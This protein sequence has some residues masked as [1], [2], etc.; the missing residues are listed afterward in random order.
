[1][2]KTL[3]KKILERIESENLE[4]R[5]KF[6]FTLREV[7]LWVGIGISAFLASVS[8][9]SFIFQSI[10]TILLPPHL[11]V[12]FGL[13]RIGLIILFIVLIVF[14]V[15]HTEKG[16][17]RKN[18]AYVAFGSIIIGIVGYIFFSTQFTG[19][20]EQRIGG[21]GSIQQGKTYWSEPHKTG[22]LAGE[23]IE[24]TDSGYVLFEALDN[25]THVLDARNIN[26]PEI[27]IDFLR[28][29]MVGYEV[30]GIYYPC[31]VSSWRLR[32]AGPEKRLEYG[33][34]QNGNISFGKENH[35]GKL[36]K[37]FLERKAEIVRTNKC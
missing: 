34:V 27:F 8:V 13:I 19:I 4:P 31:K 18:T 33:D 36:F 22:L 1:M 11:H 3:P 6:I 17:K 30:D 16:Y 5:P 10:N 2:K 12:F 15:V 37:N 20:I 35:S 28:V 23:M 14:Q 9:G 24:I 21:L 29:K 26:N 7:I 25:S 32:Q